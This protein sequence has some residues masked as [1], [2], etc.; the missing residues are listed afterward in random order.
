MRECCQKQ[1]QPFSH[2][3][4]HS[5]VLTIDLKFVWW[6]QRFESEWGSE[7][8][9]VFYP[10][11]FFCHVLRTCTCL[12]SVLS[13]VYMSVRSVTP[14]LMFECEQHIL[15]PDTPPSSLSPQSLSARVND[16]SRPRRAWRGRGPLGQRSCRSAWQHRVSHI[17]AWAELT[18]RWRVRKKRR[19]KGMK[20]GEI[21]RELGR[22][23]YCRHGWKEGKTREEGYRKEEKQRALLISWRQQGKHYKWW[24]IK[25]MP[26]WMKG[27][28]KESVR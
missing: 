6:R 23:K 10:H 11:I 8:V 19:M 25:M 12:S 20:D 22:M 21:V 7:L 1:C 2:T 9:F 4:V 26:V 17:W 27:T 13:H 14:C 5:S 15:L 24:K 18:V 3:D 28:H 16:K